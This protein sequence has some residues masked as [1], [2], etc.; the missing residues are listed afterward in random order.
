[1]SERAPRRGDVW[2]ADLGEPSG[3]EPG[4]RRPVIIVQSNPLN[5]SRLNT[6][7]VLPLTS[8]MR[9]ATAMGNVAL[10]KRQTGLP[11]ES[12]ALVCQ[13]ETLDRVF[14]DQLVGRLERSAMLRI[15]AA[16]RLCL[17]LSEG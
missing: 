12:V 14:L 3:S 9:R 7:M 13:V 17:D 2:W 11:V 15:D 4:K 1:M 6:T 10:T 5:D 16:L 8:N